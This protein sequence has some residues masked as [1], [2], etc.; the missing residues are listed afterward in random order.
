MSLNKKIIVVVVFIIGGLVGG[1][2]S[3]MVY[4]LMNR[5]GGATSKNNVKSGSNVGHQ[6]QQGELIQPQDNKDDK[7]ESKSKLEEF[8]FT[9]VDNNDK[10][11][12]SNSLEKKQ[13][14]EAGNKVADNIYQFIIPRRGKSLKR[15][16]LR[17]KIVNKR[18]TPRS[19]TMKNIPKKNELNK[20]KNF[21]ELS[22]I[23]T[24]QEKQAQKE[25]PKEVAPTDDQGQKENIQEILLENNQEQRENPKEITP[26]EKQIQKENTQEALLENNQ[27]QEVAAKEAVSQDDQV[28]R[29]LSQENSIQ[30]AIK[31]GVGVEVKDIQ[32]I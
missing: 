23:R 2:I 24:P 1:G 16:N 17:N 28:Q 6:I 13:N 8:V 32:V 30:N 22:Q 20:D 4:K 31:Q 14:R 19:L 21:K 18:D 29:E 11:S 10:V 15:L 25:T 3:F 27:E 9:K 5:K 7:H 26:Q 12:R